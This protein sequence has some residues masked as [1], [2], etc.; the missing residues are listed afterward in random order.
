MQILTPIKILYK[1]LLIKKITQFVHWVFLKSNHKRF[2]QSILVKFIQSNN[3]F[4]FF[5]PFFIFKNI[6]LIFSYYY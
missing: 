6:I 3:Q 1:N 4:I 2:P 5:F